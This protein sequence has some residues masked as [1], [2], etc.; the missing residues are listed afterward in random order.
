MA[1]GAGKGAHA[2]AYAPFAVY[3]CDVRQH[4]PAPTR[5]LRCVVFDLFIT[6]CAMYWLL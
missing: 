2:R 5:V 6:Y 4:R 3:C 1:S